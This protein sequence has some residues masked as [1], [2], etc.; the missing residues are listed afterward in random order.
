MTELT[1]EKKIASNSKNYQPD[2][3]ITFAN[4]RKLAQYL[5]KYILH[6]RSPYVQYR[7]KRYNYPTL[8]W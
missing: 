2:W 5:I 7:A 3:F 6:F 8:K 1:R 4:V